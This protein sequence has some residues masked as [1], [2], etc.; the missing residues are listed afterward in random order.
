MG[1][2][3]PLATVFQI[4]WCAPAK[5]IVTTHYMNSF[6]VILC[7]R[8]VFGALALL[9]SCSC[10]E[11]PESLVLGISCLF[12]SVLSFMFQLHLIVIIVGH[13]LH[14]CHHLIFKSIVLSLGIKIHKN[15]ICHCTTF[16]V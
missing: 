13:D 15:P 7:V 2:N 1:Q 10:R 11:H 4:S 5:T 6:T 8:V 3:L 14:V 12:S 16:S 9:K